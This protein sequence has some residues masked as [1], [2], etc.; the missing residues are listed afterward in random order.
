MIYHTNMGDVILNDNPLIKTFRDGHAA[1][2]TYSQFYKS[3][4]KFNYGF[5]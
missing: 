5:H 1:F 4:H 2:T 3:I